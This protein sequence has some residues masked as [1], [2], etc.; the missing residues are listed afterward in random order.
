M[1]E[2]EQCYRTISFQDSTIITHEKEIEDLKL[3]ITSLKKRLREA[4][5]YVGEKEKHILSGEERLHELEDKVEKLKIRIHEITG[6]SRE[7]VSSNRERTENSDNMDN[8]L[9]SILDGRLHI[10]GCVAEIRLHLDES[11]INLPDNIV[12]QF[13]EIT[14]SLTNTIRYVETT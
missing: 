7:K 8:A 1:K 13:D 14:T 9:R 10:S 6:R 3:E 12:T 5:Q 11:N 4:L 2:L